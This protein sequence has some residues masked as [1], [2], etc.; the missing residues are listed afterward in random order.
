VHRVTNS[1]IIRFL[2]RVLRQAVLDNKEDFDLNEI[3][4]TGFIRVSGYKSTISASD[5]SYAITALLETETPVASNLITED[6]SALDISHQHD[7]PVIIQSF[8]IAYDA[9]NAK[10]AGS[11]LKSEGSS[12]SNLVNGG[13]LSGSEG[14]G[15]G[16]RLAMQ[17]QKSI[18][19]AAV[20]LVDKN[21]ITRLKHFRYAYLYASGSSGQEPV[22]NLSRN[23]RK[24]SSSKD[25]FIFSRPLALCKLAHFLMDMHRDKWV[26]KNARP[27]VLLA[28][29]PKTN[30]FLV[31]G[32]NFAQYEGDMTK[33]TFRKFFQYTA[34]SMEGLCHVRLDTFEGN[35]VEVEAG[36]EHRFIEQ[37][38]YLMDVL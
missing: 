20:G 36:G 6:S 17:L 15:A 28:E 19:S 31:V 10:S 18:I 4:Y 16:I 30:T 27:L 13:D 8:N 22:S 14:L 1:T 23:A 2:Q 34:K 26:N 32:Y 38:H 9:L 37:L 12:L 7:D 35:A 3:D 5:M 11:S 24:N 21:A 29:K 33:N 25:P